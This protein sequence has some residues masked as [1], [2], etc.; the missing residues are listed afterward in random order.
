MREQIGRRIKQIIDEGTFEEIAA[1]S[2]ATMKELYTKF[3]NEN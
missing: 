2:N 1:T 3:L